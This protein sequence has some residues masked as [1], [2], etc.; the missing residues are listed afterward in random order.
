MHST[1]TKIVKLQRQ[2]KSSLFLLSDPRVLRGQAIV[3]PG[4]SAPGPSRKTGAGVKSWMLELSGIFL[5]EGERVREGR[6]WPGN[7]LK[8]KYSLK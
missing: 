7:I 3:A 1:A 5:S 6:S 4:Q 8:A 2:K